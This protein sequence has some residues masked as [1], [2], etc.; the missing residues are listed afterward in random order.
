M[1]V[2]SEV[3]EQ[4]LDYIRQKHLIV[5]TYLQDPHI[6]YETLKQ[7][8]QGLWIDPVDA[9]GCALY[10]YLKDLDMPEVEICYAVLVDREYLDATEKMPEWACEFQSLMFDD[11]R[12]KGNSV[13]IMNVYRMSDAVRVL[14]NYLLDN[15]KGAKGCNQILPEAVA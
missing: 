14:G 10:R 8:N 4:N 1:M 5:Q 13:Y 15:G 9:Q 3:L 2:S 6:V 11:N 12:S 7:K